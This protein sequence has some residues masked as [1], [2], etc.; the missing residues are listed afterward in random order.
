M[1]VLCLSVRTIPGTFYSSST[2]L[3]SM[4]LMAQGHGCAESACRH[5]GKE[6]VVVIVC[7]VYWLVLQHFNDWVI[8][9]SF[10]P[11]FVLFGRDWKT[12]NANILLCAQAQLWQSCRELQ[13]VT[14][15]YLITCIWS[16][17][18]V[19]LHC[20]PIG[21]FWVHLYLWIHETVMRHK[22]QWY[23]VLD[24]NYLYVDALDT[25]KY[26]HSIRQPERNVLLMCMLLTTAF[27]ISIVL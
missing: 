9:V 4:C 6:F 26:G 1:C 17:C 7:E 22:R 24:D 20:Y 11:L 19:G 14:Q 25:W 5:R 21:H 16:L 8:A 15:S 18:I 27:G 23:N 12:N 2:V 10:G 13:W 3:V